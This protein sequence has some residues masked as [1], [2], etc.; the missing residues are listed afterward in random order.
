MPYRRL[1]KTDQ[2][3]LQTLRQA[4][5]QAG[6]ADFM[7]QVMSFKLINE[8]QRFLPVFET[9]LSQYRQN[10]QTKVAANKQ[11][12]HIVGNARM[13]ISHFIQVLNLAVIRGDIRKEQ[14]ALYQLDI[15]EHVLPDLTTE[16][17]LLLWGQRIIDGE[18][19]RVKQGGFPI[20]NPTISKVKVHYDI[21]KEK[22]VTQ[23]QHKSN[24][25][26]TFKGM[27]SLR[28]DADKLI[29]EIW[30]TVENHYKDLPPYKRLCAC[31]K[32]GLI[33]YYR[34]GEKQLTPETD[35][36][37]EYNRQQPLTLDF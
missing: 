26:R 37:W 3:R 18:T 35:K 25:Q 32:Y 11:Y 33:Y 4:V 31:Q 19:E 27:E 17:D 10:C 2:A 36:Q 34:T 14:K 15:H 20:Y 13:Y 22:Q 21:F 8:A 12:K 9:Q 29:L 16:E 1:P 5:K 28:V 30:D 7:D 24:T 6:E 23:Q